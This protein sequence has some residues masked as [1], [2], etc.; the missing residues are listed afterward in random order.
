MRH[1]L[2]A[3]LLLLGVSLTDSKAQEPTPTPTQEVEGGSWWD[4]VV[5]NWRIPNLECKHEIRLGSILDLRETIDDEVIETGSLF[6]S[7]P[8]EE[9]EFSKHI[10]GEWRD[11]SPPS[12]SYSYRLSNKLEVAAKTL[13]MS[14]SRNTYS[15]MTGAIEES[16]TFGAIYLIPTLRYSF[17]QVEWLRY[18]AGV[19]VDLA[20]TSED[21]VGR[22]SAELCFELG[23]TL[24]AKLFFFSESLFSGDKILG[25]M[26]IGYRF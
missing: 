20:Y 18:Y 13:Y 21:G 23:F 11:F 10:R 8:Y 2:L 15:T 1:L 5:E 24:G 26:G 14:T 25:L 17:L 6:P 3:L 7:N 9:Y 22:G 16:K 19:G 12:I 4:R